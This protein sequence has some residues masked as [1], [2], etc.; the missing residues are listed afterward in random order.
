MSTEHTYQIGDR[1]RMIGNGHVGKVVGSLGSSPLYPRR[2]L[3]ESLVDEVRW[4][5]LPAELSPVAPEPTADTAA[6]PLA[7]WPVWWPE[8]SRWYVGGYG[9]VEDDPITYRPVYGR[10]RQP[11]L[12]SE[13]P[14]AVPAAVPSPEPPAEA[15]AQ[16]CGL[17]GHQA[18]FLGASVGDVDLCHGCQ[19]Y[20]GVEGSDNCQ[21]NEA[22]ATCYERWSVLDE[23]PSPA[24]SREPGPARCATCDHR[25]YPCTAPHGCGGWHHTPQGFDPHGHFPSPAASQEPGETR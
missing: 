10:I 1:V 17:C 15:A 9:A 11:L 16:T 23:R 24:A 7:G 22:D 19:P 6:E 14:G 20:T 13:M 4:Y 12:W 21:I 25:L 18:A 2:V 8:T 5:C 3:I